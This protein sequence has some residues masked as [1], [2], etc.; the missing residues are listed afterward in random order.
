MHEAL[1]SIFCSMGD[2]DVL[3]HFE[4]ILTCVANVM[5]EAIILFCENRP[6]MALS[7]LQLNVSWKHP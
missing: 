5:F 2:P 3:P 1:A 6:E 7:H 4:S